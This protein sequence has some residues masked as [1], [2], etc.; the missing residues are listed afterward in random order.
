MGLFAFGKRKSHP[1]GVVESRALS[2]STERAFATGN[3]SI[4][5]NTTPY[6]AL[7][8]PAVF[9]AMYVIA[10]SLAQLPIYVMKKGENDVVTKVT[11]HPAV[12]LLSLEPNTFQSPYK[13]KETEQFRCLGWGNCYT[14]IV[15]DRYTGEPLEF[16]SLRPWVTYLDYRI[17]PSGRRYYY[18]SLD[19]DDKPITIQL[20]DM[21]HI[22]DVGY[23]D[24][25]G[26][27]RIRQHADLI[28]WSQSMME[29]GKS[30]FGSNGKPTGA[31]TPN[32]DLTSESW[33]KL[34]A[35]WKQSAS[36]MS[37]TS[38]RT[39]LLPAELKYT[40][41][42]IP[43]EDM[44]FLDSRKMSRSEV[45][46]IFNLP[47]HMIGD[48][49]KA[50][51]SNISEQALQ[52][53]KHSIMPWVIQWEDELNRKLFT[54]AERLAGY[55][56]KF[57]L[58]VLLRGTPKDRAEF[59]KAMI[60]AGIYSRNEVRALEGKNSMDELDEMVISQNTKSVRYM[61]AEA[62]IKE[63]EAAKASVDKNENVDVNMSEENQIPEDKT[64][65]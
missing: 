23:D 51:F 24:K 30:F 32:N 61:E 37:S 35:M 55:Y 7:N 1:D 25:V 48:L 27:S 60:E 34:K 52:F 11:D 56:V 36:L 50:T 15:R 54:R 3:D 40:A 13:W 14:R 43:P 58:A 46:G 62:D 63:A 41:F 64:D 28:G 20:E 38:N 26:V 10:S 8:V 21:I 65:A 31:I 6:T 17:T 2:Q 47:P 12:L 33:E 5:V 53:V 29:Y 16:E 4:E 22:R 9:S 49:E 42:T 57:D 39:M 45:A 18:A 59:Y 19:D 44:Q